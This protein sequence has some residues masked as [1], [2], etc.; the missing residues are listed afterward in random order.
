M[1]GH[2]VNSILEKGAEKLYEKYLAPKVLPYAACSVTAE[3]S[4]VAQLKAMPMDEGER[5]PEEWEEDE[6]PQPSKLPEWTAGAVRLKFKHSM[7]FSDREATEENES[8]MHLTWSGTPQGSARKQ[9]AAQARRG[10]FAASPGRKGAQSMVLQSMR[11]TGQGSAAGSR[12]AGFKRLG[13]TDHFLETSSAVSKTKGSQ[14]KLK[15]QV[16]DSPPKQVK[17]DLPP[18]ESSNK[19]EDDLRTNILRLE[20]RK[21]KEDE[22]IEKFNKIRALDLKKLQTEGGNK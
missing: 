17:L 6:E 14:R 13:T 11:S 5:N 12:K 15:L 20:A 19:A 8:V 21:I 4:H 16:A 7:P 22:E 3:Q 9:S 18:R 10:L 1:A 2:I